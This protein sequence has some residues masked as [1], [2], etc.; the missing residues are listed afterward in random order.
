MTDRNTALFPLALAAALALAGCAADKAPEAEDAPAA[1]APA[2]AA[3][4][5]P[6]P[7]APVG[8]PVPEEAQIPADTVATAFGKGSLERDDGKLASFT[9]DVNFR[10]G[11]VVGGK[12]TYTTFLDDG[13][14]DLVA[15]VNCGHYNVDSKRAWFG[16]Q[17]SE[18]K[19]NKV[20][21]KGGRFAVGQPVWFRFE[22]SD[23]HPQ[24]PAKVSDLRFAGD[25]GYENAADFCKAQPWSEDGLRDLSAQG[26][27][28]I[29]A[30][31]E[32]MAGQ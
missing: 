8:E 20:D 17:I 21:A 23:T 27:V 29:F 22:E 12:I 30:L 11:N 31:P 14:I 6:A 1:D 28:I 2:E 9:V 7:A 10:P 25:D 15:D 3:A 32:G 4:P 18:N 24:P 5:A 26:A 16:A 13:K 19:S